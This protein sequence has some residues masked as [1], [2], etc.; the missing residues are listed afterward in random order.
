MLVI[1]LVV[2]SMVAWSGPEVRTMFE[3]KPNWVTFDP[4][5]RLKPVMSYVAVVP[6]AE[7]VT[8]PGPETF[9]VVVVPVTVFVRET[10]REPVTV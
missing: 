4:Y 10:N 9:T 8:V 2:A 5:R 3:G 1:V 6:S 7:K